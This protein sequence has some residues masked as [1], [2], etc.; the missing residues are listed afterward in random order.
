MSIVVATHLLALLPLSR[1][2]L[3][4]RDQ[5]VAQDLASPQDALHLGEKVLM[6][7]WEG[8]IISGGLVP[9]AVYAVHRKASKIQATMA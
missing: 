9:T 1:T 6:L 4:A 2:T 3:V 5:E 8:I 7:G